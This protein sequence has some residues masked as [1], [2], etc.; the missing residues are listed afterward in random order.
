MGIFKLPRQ[1]LNELNKQVRGFWCGQQEKEHKIHWVSWKQIIKSKKSRGLG[2]R[3][4]E[5]F[6]SALLAKQG[7]RI[8]SSPNSLAAR[9][10]LVWR[11]GDGN[12]IEI[13][14]DKWFPQPSTFKPQSSIRFL[15][16]DSKVAMLIDKTTNQWNYPLIEAIF[17]N[18]EVDFV[19]RIPL[20]PYPTS[21]R[22]LWKGTST[23]IFT[24]KSAYY[25]K[26]EMENQKQGQPSTAI[27]E[28]LP[29]SSIWQLSVPMA[30]KNFLWRACLEAIPT[31][32]K[33]HQRKAADEDS[34]PICK[35][36]PETAIH[37]LW[38][39]PFAQDVWSQY[40]KKIQKFSFPCLSFKTLLE[41]CLNTF[42]EEEMVE[43][44]LMAWKIWKRRNEVIFSN[45][46]SHPS[47]IIQN[48]KLLIVDLNQTHQPVQ[49]SSSL[50]NVH[51]PWEAPPQGK[52]KVN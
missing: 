6:N 4:F 27:K 30:T 43:F 12:S 21:D 51:L 39:C 26:S 17:D 44:A 46:F 23:G 25:W 37:A 1:L 13:W 29:W 22:M 36:H 34:C 32:V 9:E 15:L 8:I 52:L 18:T 3:D 40:S 48:V 35:L 7:W 16:S 10:G 42:E 45:T 28:D 41:G 14:N 20:S 33:P 2:I 31:K 49:K 24:V 19:K 38:E 5:L 11:V 47:S 50:S